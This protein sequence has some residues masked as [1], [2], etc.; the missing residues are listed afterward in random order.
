MKALT[1]KSHQINVTGLILIVLFSA[2]VL[3]IVVHV[4]AA[5]PTTAGDLDPSF[6][7]FGDKGRIHFD[8]MEIVEFAAHQD[9]GW[10]VLGYQNNRMLVRRFTYDGQPDTD[11]GQQGTATFIANGKPCGDGGVGQCGI[12]VQHDG[13]IIAVGATKVGGDY[14][15]L[16]FRLDANGALDTSFGENGSKSIDF[17]NGDDGA[18]AVAIQENG[19][20]VIVGAATD[21]DILGPDDL[22][23]G[24]VRL[25]RG[26][27]LDTSFNNTGVA[28]A[29][30]GS[31]F[32]GQNVHFAT[33]VA[34]Q[35]DGR[36][37]IAG[38]ADDS[39]EIIGSLSDFDFGLVRYNTDGTLDDSFSGNGKVKTGFD[40]NNDW[41]LA[42][43]IQS[44]GKIV[45]A[46]QKGNDS[47]SRFAMARYNKDGSLDKSFSEDGLVISNLGFQYSE[48]MSISTQSDGKLVAL[49]YG[50]GDAVMARYKGD[51]TLDNTFSEDGFRVLLGGQYGRDLAVQTDGKFVVG[52][53]SS[54]VRFYPD[55]LLDRAGKN[56]SGFG[57][58][59]DRAVAIVEQDNGYL[60]AAE[61]SSPLVSNGLDV[62]L[63]RF[64]LDGQLDR[65]FG[66]NG[67]AT[68]ELINDDSPR[69]M[70]VLPNG[71]VVIAGFRHQT[72]ND[73]FALWRFNADGSVDNDFGSH[74]FAVT[75]FGIGQDYG[76]GHVV[77]NDGKLVIAGF[78]ED[79]DGR[80][81]TM[82]RFDADGQLDKSF[83]DNG[84]FV[85][86]QGG[87]YFSLRALTALPGG[88]LLA[89]GGHAGNFWAYRFSVDGQPVSTFGQE[90]YMEY[91]LP[92]NEE[93][94]AV[95]IQDNGTIVLGGYASGDF[96]LLFINGDGSMCLDACGFFGE[97]RLRLDF[98]G[99]ESLYDMQLQSNGKIILAGSARQL[100]GSASAFF[101][102]R[103][104]YSTFP[105]TG[106]KMDPSFGNGGAIG[107]PFLY[108]ARP[109]SIALHDDKIALAGF[110]G[111]GADNDIALARLINDYSEPAT[112]R[113]I[114]LPAQEIGPGSGWKAGIQAQNN[115]VS[116]AK[117]SYTGVP[118]NGETV[119]CGES[120]EGPG[121]SANYL[122]D[123]DCP[124]GHALF[125]AGYLLT[126]QPTV[127]IA[128]L[129]NNGTGVAAGQYRGTNAA[130]A[131][132]SIFFPLVKHNHAGRTTAFSV[133]NGS[134]E[135]NDITAVFNVNGQTY[136]KEYKDV[137]GL[138]S[139]LILPAD[140]GVPAGNG[141]VGS[142][143]VTGSQRLAGASLESSHDVA[144]V[145]NLQTTSA[146][147]PADYD[148][149]LYCPLF[150][151]AHAAKLQTSGV[152]VQNVSAQTQT[153][154]FVYSPSNGGSQ[155]Q[156]TQQIQA[157]ASATF[158]APAIG[159]PAGSVGSVILTGTGNIA[160]V[161]N[162]GGTES[163]GRRIMTTY[164]CFPAQ[165]ASKKVYLPLYKEFYSGSSSGIQVQNVSGDGS[166]AVI[167]ATYSATNGSGRATFSHSTPI[168][169][170]GS[171]T[172]WGVSS[173]S[174]PQD[175][176]L[177]NGKAQELA[178]TFG[179]VVITSNQPIVAIVNETAVS[180][181][182]QDAKNYE[183]FNQAP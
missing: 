86:F 64:G 62:A 126:N 73:D 179:S 118:Q 131:N 20:I 91:K 129:N 56:S 146:F 171:I 24:T 99:D 125:S 168:P 39:S 160:A 88:D 167:K 95:V 130:A 141:Q 22:E 8:D 145:Q 58:G 151:N 18:S 7:G 164:S 27:N 37:V 35:S 175:I 183:G 180:G 44:D 81:L 65:S 162:E 2:V 98:G 11:F 80:Y 79:K 103:V 123:R 49:G 36:I 176:V 114:F 137:P 78:S 6:G 21:V 46:G 66:D 135:P 147:S 53:N 178:G 121:G 5:G 32:Y 152:Q 17:D 71:Q 75:G 106:Y 148:T 40:G 16:A 170:G 50:D 76:Q 100:S 109:L 26:G 74:G 93:A 29:S 127:A 13:G 77:Q 150:R 174:S 166:E 108:S 63:V 15:F 161:V 23:F 157:G 82:A 10:V 155:V 25:T 14:D 153:V 87:D 163:N 158:Y 143:T 34:L 38:Q 117:I 12:A 105:T 48:I 97:S 68:F 67:R 96:G 9:D 61:I 139:V 116:S 144:S 107:V 85:A 45:A 42:I 43:T 72:I 51:G 165:S 169:D 149:I 142:L 60:V 156:S 181:K 94:H 92:G 104:H 4:V 47:N 70:A 33:S 89:V 101:I 113:K 52:T 69:S 19:G 154:S 55:L 102:A 1:N 84:K 172:F 59:D 136:T 177:I 133:Q 119:L 132:K 159:I 31:G 124:A 83:A 115:G 140:A 173:L 128:S 112:F 111:N 30:F 57:F 41:A 110:T 120:S 90:G 138:V 54:V 134:E 28:T 3:L 122:T 182:E